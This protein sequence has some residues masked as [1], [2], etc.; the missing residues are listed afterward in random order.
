MP[1]VTLNLSGQR[2]DTYR[3]QAFVQANASVT[4]SGLGDVALHAKYNV[5]GRAGS[6]LALGSE[7]RLPTGNRQNL[8]GS[9]NAG[10]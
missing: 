7:V 6:G 1:F 5:L 3:G 2:I 4:A 8:L 9:G 10:R